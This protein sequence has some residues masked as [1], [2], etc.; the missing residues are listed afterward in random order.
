MMSE[1]EFPAMLPI[2]TPSESSNAEELPGYESEETSEEDFPLVSSVDYSPQLAAIMDKQSEQI[3]LLQQQNEILLE[4]VNGLS[5]VVNYQ[6]VILGV[7]VL[8][9]VVLIAYRVIFKWFFRGV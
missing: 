4:Q 2:E 1:T 7:A 3:T 9:G 8:A 5:L 6:N